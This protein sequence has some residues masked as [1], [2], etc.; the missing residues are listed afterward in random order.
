M[1]KEHP[2]YAQSLNSLADLYMNLNNYKKAELLH[3]EAKAIRE[4][5]LGK[6][7]P[8][9]AASLN[10][11]GDLYEKQSNFSAAEPLLTEA[12]ALEQV[13]LSGAA[14]YLSERELA[15]YAAKFQTDGGKLGAYLLARPTTSTATLPA[16]AFDHALFHKG[17]LLTAASWLNS[18]VAAS[19][20]SAEINNRLKGYRRRLAAEYAK[21]IAERKD[22]AEL[23]ERANNAEKELARS[24]AGYADAI[25]Q[26]KWQE[27]QSVLKRRSS[28]EF[29]QFQG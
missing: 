7:H 25:R 18:P 3:L 26:V 12:A 5:V 14:A 2:D 28:V 8:G 11:L 21:P 9:Y 24:V 20:E 27:V 19:P 15:M 16:L 13:Q 6:E 29:V 23:E 1:G 17:F 4:K 10:A 22:V